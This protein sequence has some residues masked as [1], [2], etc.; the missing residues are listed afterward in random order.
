[1][2]AGKWKRQAIAGCAA[3]AFAL[4]SAAWAEGGAVDGSGDAEREAPPA[5]VEAA[6][7]L[8]RD[9]VEAARDGQRRLDSES[10]LG[11]EQASAHAYRSLSDAKAV[12]VIEALA[13]EVLTS[14]SPH[15]GAP[16]EPGSVQRLVGSHA[17]VVE[18]GR[19]GRGVQLTAQ[20]LQVRDE[21]SGEL[22]PVDL[23]LRR[24]AGG[25]EAAQAGTPVRL[26][27]ALSGPATVG[28]DGLG[29]SVAG[30]SASA[31]GVEAGTAIVYAN[32]RSDTDIVMAPSVDGV[33]VSA[34]IRSPAA[35][36]DLTL[37]VN[38]PDG[39]RLVP[40]EGGRGGARIVDGERDAGRVSAAA[41]WDADG[42][43]VEV[44]TAVEDARMT[45]TVAHRGSEVRYPV[46][47]DPTIYHGTSGDFPNWNWAQTPAG[48]FN[49]FCPTLWGAG[50][51][52]CNSANASLAHGAW[53][54][55]TWTA[56][57]SSYV[58]AASMNTNFYAT[59][60][61]QPM[62][63]TQGVYSSL[64]AM[65][66]GAPGW[67]WSSPTWTRYAGTLNPA[68]GV[69]PITLCQ[70][71]NNDNRMQ[72]VQAGCGVANQA[73]PGSVVA[74]QLWAYG[75]AVRQYTSIN[76]LQS[77]AIWV[78]DDDAPTLAAPSHSPGL[79]AGWTH[80][81]TW[82]TTFNANDPGVGVSALSVTGPQGVYRDVCGASAA[83]SYLCKQT[84]DAQ[85]VSYSAA[86]MPT[87]VQNFAAT[88]AD[89]DGKVSNQRT[90]QVKVDN[91]APAAPVL[92][93]PLKDAAGTRI[94]Q[95]A[96]RLDISAADGT[97]GAPQ[98]GVQKAE[99]YVDGQKKATLDNSANCSPTGG[100][101]MSWTPSWDFRTQ[102]FAAGTHDITV[103]AVDQVGQAGAMS[104]P[105][106][107][108]VSHAAEAQA[109][110]GSVNLVSGNLA[111]SRSDVS[112]DSFASDL[113][114][115]RTFNSREAGTDPDGIF[116]PGWVA[117]LP[118]DGSSQYAGVTEYTQ[119]G[120]AEVT[121]ESGEAIAFE[122]SGS[123]WS[124]PPG[125][126]D[127]SLTGGS[128]V[129]PDP[130]KFT[131]QDADHA[132]TEFT[133]LAAA[134]GSG[135]RD[136]GPATTKQAASQ[137][138]TTFSYE[139]PA[140]QS[141]KRLKQVT[142]PAP[143]GVTCDPG[144][145]QR[146]CRALELDY[147]SATTATGTA[148]AQWNDYAGRLRGVTFK[149]WDPATGA[150]GSWQV[151][152]YLYDNAGR[153]R[154]A[155]DP[156]ISPALK[157]TYA[158]DSDGRITTIDPPDS[159]PWTLAYQPGAG[160]PASTGRLRTASRD[161]PTST[162]TQ[163]ATTTL[164]YGVPVSGAGAPYDLSAGAA[165]GWGQSQA[166]STATAV[167]PPDQVPPAPPSMPSTYSRAT[168]HYL[169]AKGREV[170]TALPGPRISATEYDANDNVAGSLTAAN[171]AAGGAPELWTRHTYS[172]DGIDLL[173]ETGPRRQVK[174]DSGA[175]AT[176]RHFTSTSYTDH[177]PASRSVSA[178]LDDG[179]VADTRAT[180]YGYDAGGLAARKPS[181]TT[182][183]PGG[184]G[185]VS[186]AHYDTGTGQEI[187]RR[188]PAGTGSD[189]RSRLTFYYG[190]TEPGC[191]GNPEWRG[192]PCKTRPAAQPGTPGQP[193]LPISTFQYSALNQLTVRSDTSG[194]DT[195]TTTTS[196]DAA[197]RRTAES[198]TS[199]A[200]TALPSV[201]YG[202]DTS[203]GR[204]TTT[205]AGGR[206]VTR[207]YDSVGHL[208]SYTDA[209]GTTSTTDFD[210]LGR[211]VSASD[212]KGTQ[213]F[214]Y[215]S[216][217]G[218]LTAVA[219]SPA[220]TFTA[221]YD[222]D[223]RITSL[224]YPGGIVAATAYDAAGQPT[225]LSYTKTT[226]C[227][228]GC[229]WLQETAAYSALGQMRSDAG[230][231]GDRAY[232]YDKAGRLVEARDT[233]AGQGCTIR[234]YGYDA[235]SNRTS[236]QARA[237]G[238]GGACDP[239]AAPTT[240][241]SSYDAADRL[242][243][244]GTAYDAFGR[245][246]AVPGTDAGGAPITASYYANDLAA[247]A[248]QGTEARA[249][250]LDP[251]R[252]V[253]TET[254]T[255]AQAAD[256][257]FHYT[258]DSDSPAWS[259]ETADGMNWARNITGPAGDIAAIQNSQTGTRLQLPNLHGDIAAT[260]SPDPNAAGL[261]ASLRSDE[262][263]Q[264]QG[265]AP[266]RYQWLGAKR[267][268]TTLPT[269]IIL[270]GARLYDPAAGRFLQTDPIPGGS[271]NDYDYANQ[272]PINQYDLSGEGPN[273]KKKQTKKFEAYYCDVRKRNKGMSVGKFLSRIYE[274]A[275]RCY[276]GAKDGEG[277]PVT[278]LIG[279]G[280]GILFG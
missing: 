116:G 208:N 173:T 6:P 152:A 100:C 72:C 111:L 226:N 155:W 239:A 250:S 220:G 224:G 177:L 254:A 26:P 115:S 159:P 92:S 243:T 31:Q 145:L 112:I 75:S 164:V 18:D 40:V 79:P 87:G 108:T 200:G 144:A 241:S 28:E 189:A 1:M 247:S 199:S 67:A 50:L 255:G 242:I 166:P 190:G 125:Y 104:A 118:V 64:H 97:A 12:E 149:A 42:R 260:V 46:T 263:G 273:C 253:R 8:A 33:E 20:P 25:F 214:T 134:D 212:G 252:R 122:A 102:R 203:T 140:G 219:D 15:A 2:G 170:D 181:T 13:P 229:V 88:V 123:S 186:T 213:S 176:A 210:L 168:V 150:M 90:W 58:Y 39:Q 56:P 280:L 237:P 82:T 266:A 10:A 246:T 185:L 110:P 23:R 197:G 233:P 37:E 4:G 217:T 184:L 129:S 130:N 240:K 30:A 183:D 98:S 251:L 178:K 172:A 216:V 35:P 83:T 55:W 53:A 171:R 5:L 272:D 133:P 63:I 215:D 205:S 96:Y 156:R 105:V 91:T 218:D 138:Q 174:L 70:S 262:F 135:R 7:G 49:L 128:I 52:S 81:A 277:H 238:A 65:W 69:P 38:L 73:G 223:G 107:V 132:V 158:Y 120:V 207:G 21:T 59:T 194:A 211:P 274:T 153:L 139:T 180:S 51:Y 29:V 163:T 193:D 244:A 235:D 245:A 66:V 278:V 127:L 19:G 271:A 236:L 265:P 209:D 249:W 11:A 137:T 269:G 187:E 230:T 3:G 121:L 198:V 234:T 258:S 275:G 165:A 169:D 32:A 89:T 54:Q 141:R 74:Y 94:G 161:V 124:P 179:S 131:L 78:S 248:G 167:F 227:S 99:V 267:R 44:R 261:T 71:H 154:A 9:A 264:P 24:V 84:M 57:G 142:A 202:Y 257:T 16:G 109:G 228:S 188:L 86:Q 268:Q 119:D 279:C 191:T 147:A 62:C 80:S 225:G 162:G 175:T 196:Y 151:A 206:T 148:E 60:P 204:L 160:E 17:A 14:A 103:R 113:S 136:Y 76:Q 93:G 259:A 222:A 48:G 41:A 182:V 195:R 117:S 61:S 45:L 146:G 232:A 27:G 114:V 157:E 201:S 22:V 77:L 47:V 221:G 143:P 106:T 256:R 85:Q 36:E 95:E 101:P 43:P 34:V 68:S 126:E 192:L 270:M 231:Q 276:I